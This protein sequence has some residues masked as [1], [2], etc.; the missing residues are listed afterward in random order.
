MSKHA[1]SALIPVLLSVPFL[2]SISGSPAQDSRPASQD[3]KP[4][5]EGATKENFDMQ[6]YMQLMMKLATPGKEHKQLMKMVGDWDIVTRYRM[7]NDAPWQE[8]KAKASYKSV[9]GGRWLMQDFEG[10]MAGMPFQ[11][12]Q[13]LGYDKLRKLYVSSWRD[14]MS[15]W[16]VHTE[17]KAAKDGKSIEMSGLMVDGLTPKGRKMRMVIKFLSD[18]KQQFDMYDTIDGKEVWV[19]SQLS[20]KKS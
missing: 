19:M 11:G 13:F 18:T 1:L 2:G 7:A 9:L 5:Q 16:A 17:G 20:T 3:A 15:T 14:S 8:G 10:N 4:V 6:K 12:L